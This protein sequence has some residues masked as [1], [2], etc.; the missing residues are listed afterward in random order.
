[1]FFRLRAGLYRIRNRKIKTISDSYMAGGLPP[2]NTTHAVDVVNAALAMQR[3]V[4]EQ[5]EIRR[6]KGQTFFEIRLG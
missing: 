2:P 1:M 3:F 6:A 5:Q 4:M